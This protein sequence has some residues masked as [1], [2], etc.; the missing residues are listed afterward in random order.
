MTQKDYYKT[1]GLSRDASDKDIKLAYRRLARKYHP[2]L[3]KE[4]NAEEQFKALGEAYEVL[5]DP[6]KRRQYDQFGAEPQQAPPYEWRTQAGPGPG[7]DSDWFESIFGGAGGFRN[8]PRGGDDVHASIRVSLE[9]A[10]HGAS[11]QIVWQG[12]TLR[13]K[14]PAGVTDGQQIRLPGRGEAGHAGGPSGHLFITVQVDKHPLYEVVGQDVYL[15]LPITPWEAAL[16]AKIKVPTL[17]GPI[18]LTVP[19]GSQ[20]GQSLRLKQRGLPGKP[21]GDQ[22][23]LLKIVTPAPKTEQD[24]DLYRRMA[25]AMPLN[26]RDKMGGG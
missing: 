7:V 16:G 15:T 3:N 9:E 13:I 21:Q 1:M 8:R 4:P 17:G 18:D 22:Y 19:A 23:L 12:S 26:P 10:Y 6:E 2:D 14:I 5:K 24:K 25:E 11:K 20:G